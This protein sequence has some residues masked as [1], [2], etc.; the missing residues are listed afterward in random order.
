ML[1]L[2]KKIILAFVLPGIIATMVVVSFLYQHLLNSAIVQWQNDNQYLIHILKKHLID[3]I[4]TN[5]QLLIALSKQDAFASLQ[6]QHEIDPAINGIAAHLDIKKRQLLELLQQNFPDFSVLF[7]LTPT[8]DHYISHPFRVQQN[9]KRF[10]LSGRHYFIEATRTKLPVISDTFIGAD[11]IPAIVIDVPIVNSKEQIIAHLGGVFH[12]D[13][14]SQLVAEEVISPFD[15]GFIVDRKNQL[16]AATQS[17]QLEDKGQNISQQ[18]LFQQ[19]NE[20][21]DLRSDNIMRV[22]ISPENKHKY[23]LSSSSLNNGWLLVL[24][25]DEKSIIDAVYPQVLSI[26]LLVF[27]LLT[28][29]GLIGFILVVRITRRWEHAEE[30][31]HQ[32][33]DVLEQRVSERTHELELS[34]L[35][36]RRLFENSEISIWNEDLSAVLQALQK[37]R[38]DGVTDLHAYL[39]NHEQEVWALLA[40]TRVLHVNEATLELFEAGDEEN[41]IN[42]LHSVFGDNAFD[43]FINELCAIWNGCRVFR[44]E[45]DFITLKGKSFT[46]IIAFQ[47]PEDEKDFYSLPIS[48]HDISEQKLSERKI[49]KL[50]RVVE[51]SPVSVIITDIMGNI[52]YVNKQFELVTG[53]SSDEVV[54]QTPRLLKSGET[55]ELEYQQLWQTIVSGNVWTGVFH[56]KTKNGGL[57]W[58]KASISSLKN[59][60]GEITHFI[61]IKEDISQRKKDEER[62]RY[63]ASFD[64]LTGLANRHLFFEHFNRALERAKREHHQVALFFIDLDRFKYVNDT[65][66]HMLGDQLLQEAGKRLL[67]CLRKS[68]TVARLGGDEFAIILPDISQLSQVENTLKKLIDTLAQSYRLKGNDAFVS[69]SVGVTLYPQD[70]LTTQV[71]ISNADSAMYKAKENGRNGF[72]FFTAQMNEEAQQ[73]R[74]LESALYKA[75]DQQEFYIC[76]QP[77]IDLQKNVVCSAEALI[78]WQHPK[79]GI[80]SPADFIPLAE[81]I[82]LIIPIGEWVLYETCKEAVRWEKV[83]QQPPNVAVNLSSCQ[84]QRQNIP[85]LIQTVLSETGL[86]AQRLTL[87]ITESLLV[88]DN[89]DILE[90]LQQLR[91]MGVSL[92]IDDFGTGY[93]SLSYLKKF[94]INVLKIDR[95]FIMELPAN[96]EDAALVEAILSM[97]HSLQLKVVAE[98][99]ETQE[100]VNFLR[101]RNC[102]SVQ[103]FFYSKPLKNKDFLI[104]LTH[105]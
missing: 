85:Q 52:E 87:E 89:Q 62:I 72:Y 80:I 60:A 49:K 20:T 91:N 34:E 96:Q 25:R 105:K 103:G 14:L 37:L 29:I 33:H 13:K 45:V 88:E 53:F 30:Q 69:A 59:Q 63:Q 101:A 8:G 1:T 38:S 7:V 40:L 19:T 47:I 39:N 44:S 86:A 35:R 41:F 5:K 11:A 36:Y 55:S 58:E 90:Q 42:N 10:N 15:A 97:A 75:L 50:S 83:M 100:Q 78:R 27:F 31:L 74:V 18:L 76:F 68:D 43:V 2:R 9:L 3:K 24:L 93:S 48:I 102:Q 12:L 56:N 6:H 54:G 67:A 51:Q 21:E 26:S 66:G 79:K 64:A 98:G 32:A 104:F 17:M 71:L 94:P 22:Y 73:R 61:A 16:I 70:G 95:S 4:N 77:I 46:A 82:A 81:E 23:L 84:F 99:V 65:L 92:S 57:I 28:G